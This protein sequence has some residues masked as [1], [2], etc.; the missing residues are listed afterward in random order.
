MTELHQKYAPILRF[1]Q[2]ERF[3]PMRVDELLSYSS[4]YVKDRDEPLVRRSEV[5]PGDLMEHRHSPEVFLRSVA[6]GPLSGAEIAA[7]WG[8]GT[9]E[10]VYRWA[11]QTTIGWS[12]ELL[13]KA[14]SWFNAKTVKSAQMFWWHHLILGAVRGTLDSVSSEKLPRLT[15][16]AEIHDNAVEQYE[17]SR[18]TS[19]GYTYYYREVPDGD[20]LCLQYWFFYG[21]ND[22]G[23]SFAGLNDHEG[24]WESM[25]LFFRLDPQGRPQEP[26]SHITFAYHESR[27][28]KV[29][30]DAE[31]TRIGTHPVGYAGAGSHATYPQATIYPLLKRYG[32]LDYAPGD[33]VT[34]DHDEW[35]HRINLD[36]VPWLSGYQGSWGTRYWLS[37]NTAMSML[38]MALA[39]IP[40]S[41][42]TG[43]SVPNEIELPGVS[44]PHGPVS[45][46][47]LQTAHPVEWAGVLEM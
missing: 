14:Y 23:L 33:G 35:M 37:D 19:P 20:F 27:Q 24:D 4:L 44:A 39:A 13:H 25:Y 31:I 46:H 5:T 7:A 36:E 8:E 28:T 41:G 10:M 6:V 26:P 22:W 11:T 15:L 1:D 21:Y 2:R 34:I 29:W 9:L 47:R 43:L 30:D 40:I 45:N 16:P 18:K 38:Q 17:L 32:L 3:F 12:Q 42:V